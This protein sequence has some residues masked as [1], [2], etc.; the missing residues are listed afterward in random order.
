MTRLAPDR[1]LAIGEAVLAELPLA[2][3]A[4]WLAIAM[5]RD[6]ARVRPEH[7]SCRHRG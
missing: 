7:V 4:I 5:T 6:T 2:A 1:L 3:A